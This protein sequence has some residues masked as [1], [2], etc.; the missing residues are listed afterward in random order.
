[1][2]ENARDISLLI[3]EQ[4]PRL[5]DIAFGLPLIYLEGRALDISDKIAGRI[6]MRQ[7]NGIYLGHDIVFLSLEHQSEKLGRNCP[8]GFEVFTG[9]KYVTLLTSDGG[10]HFGIY[11]SLGFGIAEYIL[12]ACNEIEFLKWRK[13]SPAWYL[14]EEN[15]FIFDEDFLNELNPWRDLNTANFFASKLYSNMREGH[16]LAASLD[17]IYDGEDGA[18]LFEV[19][20]KSCISLLFGKSFISVE[21]HPN[22]NAP[23]RRDI[24]AENCGDTYFWKRILEDYRARLVVFEVK[25]YSDIGVNELRQTASYLNQPHYGNIA[26]LIYRTE[27]EKPTDNM[28]KHFRLQYNSGY[29]KKVNVLISTRFMLE[30]LNSLI[31]GNTHNPERMMRHMLNLHLQKYLYEK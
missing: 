2:R 20:C 6:C 22:G 27:L 1:M 28:L 18:G 23:E 12:A 3:V 19:W 25:N 7:K 17:F 31:H 24:V 4:I 14:E 9:S 26:F 15:I 13:G 30:M 29:D 11:E 8:Y 16:Y 21:L 5:E 10:N